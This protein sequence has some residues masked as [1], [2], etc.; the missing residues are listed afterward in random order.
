MKEIFV[1]R[2]IHYIDNPSSVTGFFPDIHRI[3]GK[4][5]F[6]GFMYSFASTGKFPSKQSWKTLVSRNIEIIESIKF[7]CAI[8]NEQSLNGIDIIHGEGI[9]CLI[10]EFSKD[11]REHTNRSITVMNLLSRLFGFSYNKMCTL[12]GSQTDSIA[13]H[14]IMYCRNNCSVRTRLW[15]TLYVY[16][17]HDN[18]EIFIDLTPREQCIE[19]FASLPSF[20]LTRVNKERVLHPY[21]YFVA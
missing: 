4:Y 2:I 21:H 3:L 13:V 10:W 12:C 5:G 1:Y 18:Y 17:G 7:Q 19:M 8:A 15:N 6:E 16:L 20:T 11:N 14:L 9:P